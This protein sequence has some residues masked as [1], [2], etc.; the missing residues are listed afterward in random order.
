MLTLRIYPPAFGEITGSPFSTKALCLLNRSG[1]KFRTE[2]T[3]DPRKQ[4]K[5]KFPVLVDDGKIVPDSDQIRDHIEEK[6]AFDFDEGLSAEQRA[7]SRAVIR[8]TEE[9]IYFAI[10]SNRWQQ[11]ENWPLT[12]QEFFGGMPGILRNFI[13]GKIRK[14]VVAALF[15]QGMGRHSLA[16]QV[17][18]VRHDIDAI[19]ALLGDKPFLFGENPTAG[20]ASVVPML[21]AMAFYPQKSAL[22]D[23]VL[24][25]PKLMAYLERGKQEMYPV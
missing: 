6:Y 14:N 1:L 15:G 3:P 7:V 13:S 24:G 21:R 22:S 16:E 11:D 12:R 20:D 19:E 4:P 2:V 8:M 17:E 9:N 25:R 10:V 5:Q 23:L 18:R